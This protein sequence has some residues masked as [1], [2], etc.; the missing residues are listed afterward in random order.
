M[1]ATAIHS[2]NMAVKIPKVLT[3]VTARRDTQDIISTISVLVCRYSNIV[4]FLNFPLL[5][6]TC[7]FL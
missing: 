4:A 1:N 5:R 2:V 3:D 6:G 7:A